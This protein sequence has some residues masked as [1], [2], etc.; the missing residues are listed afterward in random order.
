MMVDP[1]IVQPQY[2]VHVLV[3]RDHK[4]PNGVAAVSHNS[5]RSDTGVGAECILDLYFTMNCLYAAHS[6]HR[7]SHICSLPELI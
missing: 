7:A 3:V 5:G 1:A 6:D 4:C 2:I